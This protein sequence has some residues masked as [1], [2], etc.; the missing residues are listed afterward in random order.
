M[1]LKKRREEVEDLGALVV[2]KYE[3]LEGMLNMLDYMENE[4]EREKFSLG[5]NDAW[6][7]LEHLTM[8]LDMEL[9]GDEDN[10]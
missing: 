1:T 8:E 4:V 9:N 6:C 7:E 10:G 3:L 2:E 5:F